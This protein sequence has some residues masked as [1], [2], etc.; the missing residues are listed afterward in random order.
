MKYIHWAK[1]T[2]V[3]FKTAYKMPY[4]EYRKEIVPILN[5]ILQKAIHTLEEISNGRGN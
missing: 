5:K 2:F 1:G 3:E 4:D